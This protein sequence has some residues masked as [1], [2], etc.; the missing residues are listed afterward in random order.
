MR[1]IISVKFSCMYKDARKIQCGKIF[2]FFFCR[3]RIQ[4]FC[5]M[6]FCNNYRLAA[7]LHV[8][9]LPELITSSQGLER[10]CGLTTDP[11]VQSWLPKRR[12]M[13][14]LL[15]GFMIPQTASTIHKVQSRDYLCHFYCKEFTVIFIDWFLLEL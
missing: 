12:K 2:H 1:S 9:L 15:I 14:E 6:F 11:Q 7:K 13:G 10:G 4:M 5:S 8:S 3:H